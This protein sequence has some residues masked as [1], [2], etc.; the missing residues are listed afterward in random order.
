MSSVHDSDALSTI[1]SEEFRDGPAFTHLLTPINT[2]IQKPYSAPNRYSDDEDL[3]RD[4]NSTLASLIASN[5]TIANTPLG[6]STPTTIIRLR[7]S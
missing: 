2:G 7:R 1:L 4:Y 6:L 5:D 3:Y